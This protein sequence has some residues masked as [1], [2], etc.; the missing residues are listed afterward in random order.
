MTEYLP[1]IFR[2]RNILKHIYFCTII[3]LSFICCGFGETVSAGSI[4][5]PLEN[6]ITKL[7]LNCGFENVKV[8]LIENDILIQY[9]NRIY[10][11]EIKA[12]R[13]IAGLLT[14]DLD[15]RENLVLVPYNRTIPLGVIFLPLNENLNYSNG[16][17]ATENI[18]SAVDVSI[19]AN[20]F[21]ENY[22]FK[23]KKLPSYRNI[24]LIFNSRVR[25]LF[26]TRAG[27]AP[28]N[29]DFAPAL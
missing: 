1:T 23:K 27:V 25:G 15:G 26:H 24:E 7:L 20:S 12:I 3:F 29:V 21:L 4:E 28:W 17:A 13:R 5:V 18:Q 10:R 2:F 19:D 6:R 14:Q 8:S 22:K 11:D 9:E 16:N